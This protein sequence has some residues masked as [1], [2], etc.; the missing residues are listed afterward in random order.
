MRSR[1]PQYR[2]VHTLF[3][4][5]PSGLRYLPL[6][7][8]ALLGGPLLGQEMEAGT[9][10]LDWVQSIGR[11]EWVAVR[12]AVANGLTAFAAIV[13]T[14]PVTWWWY[15]SWRGHNHSGLDGKAWRALTRWND[16]DF[17][18]YTGPVGV[19]HLL[20]ALMIGAVTGLLLRRTLPTVAVSAALCEAAL[21]GLGALRPH[22]LTPYVVRGYGRLPPN[23]PRDAWYLGSGNVRADGT[24]TTGHPCPGPNVKDFSACLRQHHVIGQYD[25]YL[26]TSQFLPLQLIETAISL[27]AATALA[28]FCL[29][30]VNR[31]TAR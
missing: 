5:A 27:S 28:A 16:W 24:L 22:L 15:A 4:W 23:D 14:A 2:V 18:A 11:R 21:S 29:W 6:A 13:L 31:V 19:A 17:F 12:L 8:G 1:S 30:Y 10:R 9:H 7:V 25:S 26:R 20:L 3:N